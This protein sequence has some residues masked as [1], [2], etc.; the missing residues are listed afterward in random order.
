[1]ALQQGGTRKYKERL[2]HYFEIGKQVGFGRN[3][4][5]LFLA[6]KQAPHEVIAQDDSFVGLMN[7]ES[8]AHVVAQ[9]NVAQEQQ[10]SPTSQFKRFSFDEN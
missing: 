8:I 10:S 5:S 9:Q 7:D 2:E 6:N 4:W 3:N 1:L